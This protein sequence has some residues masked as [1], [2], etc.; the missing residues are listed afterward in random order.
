MKSHITASFR[1][2]FGQLSKPLQKQAREAYRHFQADPN[3]PGLH[4]KKVHPT[5][6]IHSAR[7][8]RG[9]R[10]V[11]VL[12]GEEIV[13]F[14][15]LRCERIT[16]TTIN[17]PTRQCRKESG[18]AKSAAFTP[19]I[20]EAA[21][22]DL[23]RLDTPIGLLTV[24]PSGRTSILAA[25]T[26]KFAWEPCCLLPAPARI[27]VA[28]TKPAGARAVALRGNVALHLDFVLCQTRLR[29][30]VAGLHLEQEIH[31]DA[32]CLLKAE[33]HFSGQR[34]MAV[35][36]IR[37][38]G[39]ADAKE[40]RGP[41]HRQAE[42]REDVFPND[43]AG[44]VAGFS[45]TVVVPLVEALQPLAPDIADIHDSVYGITVRRSTDRGAGDECRA[46]TP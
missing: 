35:E 8:G 25:T 28:D 15:T 32:K 10:A 4:F 46:V 9:H 34:G 29:R 37:K 38:G 43:F 45:Y 2:S 40:R 42:R 14:W 5:M 11:G 33:S 20:V 1:R 12:E 26:G 17:C 27:L 31:A 13:W 22:H 16:S 7:V 6:P 44:V 39:S 18:G 19:R 24:G 3:H 30:V 36:Y 23:E 21:S 41:R